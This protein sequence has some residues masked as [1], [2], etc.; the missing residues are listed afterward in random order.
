MNTHSLEGE[1]KTGCAQLRCIYL[2]EQWDTFNEFRI[3]R[4]TQRL[5]PYRDTLKTLPWQ[6]AA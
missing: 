2:T 3:A 1:C 6:V 4:E 5:Y